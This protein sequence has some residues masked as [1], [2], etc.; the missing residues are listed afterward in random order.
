MKRTVVI[1]GTLDTK[2]TEVAFLKSFIEAA[3]Y[4]A[5]VID[6]GVLEPPPFAPE[7][8]REEVA[9]AG[10]GNVE[11]LVE[12]KQAHA[13]EIMRRGAAKI[14]VEMY[15]KSKLN[16][17][18]AIG[19]GQGTALGTTA[20]RNLPIGI[21][22]VMVSTLASGDTRPYVGTKDITMIHSVVDI[23]GLNRISRKILQ[24]AAGAIC[25]MVAARAEEVTSDKPLIGITMFGVTTPC[26]MAAKEIL[27]N[28]GYETMVFHCTGT[29][30]K[31][32]EELIEAGEVD[33]VLDVTTTELADELAGGVLSA[34]PDRLEAAGKRGIPQIIAPGA[35]EMVNFGK[36][37]T[38]PRGYQQR[39]LYSHT[40]MVTLM[41][42]NVEENKRL[43]EMIARKA[44]KASGPT[45]VAIPLRGFS[46]YDAAGMHFYHPEANG[47]FIE[48]LKSSLS[49]KVQLIEMD[50]HIN[51]Q[52]FAHKIANLLMAMMKRRQ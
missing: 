28:N 36:K 20:M 52:E 13:M 38:V 17:I 47:A 31:A 3:G 42:T 19:G 37:D 45:A 33:G 26:V 18:I 11:E 9:G 48:A 4:R 40:P 34:G 7:V 14:V 41:R 25:G 23:A 1:I 16:G 10:G 24:N 32:L 22:K 2:G 15:A 35:L 30:G 44:N 12:A 8:T 5:V 51:D 6:A 29:G 50:Y 21:P 39:N 27:E 43:G 49:S 46:A